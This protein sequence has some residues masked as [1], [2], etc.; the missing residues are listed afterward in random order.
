[1]E[2]KFEINGKK[3]KDEHKTELETK[4]D[5]CEKKQIINNLKNKKFNFEDQKK[6]LKSRFKSFFNVFTPNDPVTKELKK[7]D[8]DVIT[9][10]QNILNYIS[11][12]NLK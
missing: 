4:I 9:N 7:F 10:K 2:D 1:M 6:D 8:N 5:Q 11:N 12:L 3:L